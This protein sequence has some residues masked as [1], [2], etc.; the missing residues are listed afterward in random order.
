MTTWKQINRSKIKKNIVETVIKNIYKI[1]I[2]LHLVE[3]LQVIYIL[4]LKFAHS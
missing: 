1:H 2:C 4:L 3:S